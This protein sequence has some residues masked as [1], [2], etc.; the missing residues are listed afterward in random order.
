M[1]PE[2]DYF[3]NI[4]SYNYMGYDFLTLS[5]AESLKKFHHQ[6]GVHKEYYEIKRMIWP[7]GIPKFVNVKASLETG[8]L[9]WYKRG[10]IDLFPPN[11]ED[12]MY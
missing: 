6:N 8:I 9:Q 1:K 4:V 10:D 5:D 2:F 3:G 11:I 12:S 7:I